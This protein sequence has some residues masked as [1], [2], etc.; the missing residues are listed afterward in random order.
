MKFGD[1]GDC[2]QMV[3]RIR[4]RIEDLRQQKNL[5]DDV[6]RRTDYLIKNVSY[7]DETN[8]LPAPESV[9]TVPQSF[10]TAGEES[11]MDQRNDAPPLEINVLLDEYWDIPSV[12]C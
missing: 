1:R 5:T 12:L 7:S 3:E 6:R 2:D 11:L 9:A 4:E 10:P 8:S